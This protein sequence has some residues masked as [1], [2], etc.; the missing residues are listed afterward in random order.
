MLRAVSGTKGVEREGR[1]IIEDPR[2][3]FH[4]SEDRKVIVEFEWAGPIGLHKFEG[5]WKDPSGKVT[6]VSDYQF[7][8]QKSEFAGYWTMLIDESATTGVWTLEARIDGE[9]AGSFSFEIVAGAGTTPV[10]PTRAPLTAAEIYNQA[11][12]GT[13]FVEKFDSS[14]KQIERT[15]GFLIG[16]G[17]VL[18]TFGNID[19]A[20]AL[21][22]YGPNGKGIPTSQVLGWDRLQDWA[23]LRVDAEAM[24]SLKL[25]A[26]KS[27][28]VG[29]HCYSFGLSSA[30]GRVINQC[31]IVGHESEPI[32][33][34]RLNLST[35]FDLSS[36]GSPVLN[37]FGE[38]IGVLAASSVP[39]SHNASGGSTI[40]P[41]A[42]SLA[43]PPMASVLPVELVRIPALEA[44]PATLADL[45][46]KGEFMPP[47]QR[48]DQVGFG[49]FA[50]GIDRKNGP[51]WP[52]DV[53]DQ[54]SHG[55]AQMIVFINWDPKI[56]TSGIATLKFYSLEN[57]QLGETRPLKVNIRPGNFTSSYWTVSIA[58][59]PI[60]SY[61]A[62][63]CLGDAPVWR[64]F[65]RVLP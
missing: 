6:V 28:Y 18:T 20:S 42:G 53:R 7:D 16:P 26:V 51:G 54:F 50:L 1:F 63:V 22:I 59:F 49:A 5:L 58:E 60:G 57:K 37:E 15:S 3:V 43:Q 19:G 13:V 27:W 21:R 30:G 55:D 32:G 24:P 40:P 41:I 52:R 10:T 65:F 11:T 62:D 14:G 47:L 17:R 25:A 4:P 56:K 9:T 8:A 44:I 33:G 35:P 2:T 36:I 12:A 46:A 61:R 45:M 29:E 31:T 48:Q 64:Q 39:G 38:V 34:E 23:V